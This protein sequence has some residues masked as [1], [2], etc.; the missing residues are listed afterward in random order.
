MDKSVILTNDIAFWTGFYDKEKPITWASN[1]AYFDMNRTMTFRVS[2]SGK[3][4]KEKSVIQGKRNKWKAEVTDII[5]NQIKEGFEDFDAWHKET[6]DKIINYYK[7]TR[8]DDGQS[9]LVC[10]EGKERTAKETTL[11]VGQAQKWLNMT[12]KYLWLLDRLDLLKSDFSPFVR[13]HQSSFH[14][15]LDSYIIRYVKREPKL[16]RCKNFPKTN[17]LKNKHSIEGMGGSQW[18]QIDNYENYLKYQKSIRE[19][20][21]EQ[22]KSPIEWELEYWHRAIVYYG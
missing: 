1:K 7:D 11:T 3:T 9:I 4:E 19:D 13:K 17:G 12:L 21:E 22:G 2:D 20:L 15:P 10:R 8:D 16:K 14:I 5:R 18:S 6:C